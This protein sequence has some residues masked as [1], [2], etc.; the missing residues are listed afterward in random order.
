MRPPGFST[1]AA[2]KSRNIRHG[3]RRVWI[4]RTGQLDRFDAGS[5]RDPAGDCFGQDKFGRWP[6]AGIAKRG[7]TASADH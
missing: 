3:W 2:G 6:A 1:P 5:T 4:P 7:R